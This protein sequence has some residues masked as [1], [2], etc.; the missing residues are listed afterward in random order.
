[1]ETIEEMER[2]EALELQWE[3]E[4]ELDHEASRVA[5]QNAELIAFWRSQE[6]FWEDVMDRVWASEKEAKKKEMKALEEE[7]LENYF[8]QLR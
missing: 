3:R 2:L 4:R 8:S 7:I 1:M 6:T 5:S